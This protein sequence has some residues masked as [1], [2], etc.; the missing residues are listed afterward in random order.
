MR[1][2]NLDLNLLVALDALLD[3]QSVTRAAERVNVSQPAMSAALSRLREHFGE[4]ILQLQGKTMIPTAA[5]LRM[6]EPIKQLLRDIDVLVTEGSHFDPATS[7]RRFQIATSDFLLT[8]LFPKLNQRLDQLAPGIT[9]D[10]IQPS[11]QSMQQLNQGEL[12][13]FIIPEEHASPNHPTELLFEE[14][15]VV[16]GCVNNPILNR[17][18]ISEEDFFDAGHVVV[19]I[20][21]LSRTS[22]AESRLRKHHEQRRIEMRVSS[23]LT[24]PEM[25]INTSRLTVMHK[26]LA[27]M[28]AKRLP[29]AISEMPFEFPAMREVIQYQQSRQND[30]GLR[31]LIDQLKQSAQET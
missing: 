2:K 28:Y 10:C 1:F 12:D 15:Y 20:G 5:A 25:V 16:V 17:K 23:F 3:E 22:F 19:E 8:V 7:Q 18:K 21:R 26:R 13:L 30:E 11:E 14:N 24:A 27:S 6:R 4:P 9:M 29:I 31:W